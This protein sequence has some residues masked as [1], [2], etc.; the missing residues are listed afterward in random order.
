MNRT[1]SQMIER[2]ALLKENK[3]PII[4]KIRSYSGLILALNELDEL[5]EMNEAKTS[6][7]LQ[8][9]YILV[10]LGSGRKGPIFDDQ[11][12]HTVISGPPGTGKTQ[13]GRVLS[14]I[15]HSLGLLK[16]TPVT[17]EKEKASEVYEKSRKIFERTNEGL[18]R[19]A[20]EMNTI[21]RDLA[22]GGVE[23]NYRSAAR[24]AE[25][26][27]QMIDLIKGNRIKIPSQK[28][29]EEPIF[30]VVS[31]VDFVA[32][33]LGQTAIKTKKLLEE[34]LGGV[35]FIDEAYS[36][37]QEDRDSFGMEALT[38]LNQ[39][40]SEHPNEIIVIFAG[41]TDLLNKTIFL[42]QP[43]LK[44]R[45]SWYF[46]IEKYTGEGLASIFRLQMK[47]YGWEVAPTIDLPR[48][49]TQHIDDFTNYGG[50]T[51]KFAF[52]CKLYHMDSEFV[53]ISSESRK[54]KVAETNQII[55][56]ETLKIAFDKYKQNR[57]ERAELEKKREEEE[58]AKMI[59]ATLYT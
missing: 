56:E 38:T 30:R 48:F 37:I 4:E 20:R 42:R 55:S 13:L 54:R 32:G 29:R 28:E 49:F 59:M 43:G 24:M 27:R 36:L 8:L 46:D 50:D 51:E 34:C 17:K 3:S 15:W 31:R 45:C 25:L 58:K 40:M 2:L 18:I 57:V 12:L 1:I 16:G 44:R 9:E 23:A 52:Y 47:K 14:K 21:A 19:I 35:L 10:R 6:I 11:M 33:Y 53:R 7:V 26:Q 39:F 5:I 41:Y 22:I